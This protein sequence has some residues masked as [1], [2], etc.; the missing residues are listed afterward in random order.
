MR[1]SSCQQRMP[2]AA[3]VAACLCALLT[4][5][6]A[7]PAAR[8]NPPPHASASAAGGARTASPRQRVIRVFT[9][10]TAAMAGAF[11]SRN[12]R[13]VHE[14]LSRYLDPATIRN[15]IR[16]F[17]QAWSH[18]EISYGR[19]E[20]HII[21]VRIQG[22]TAWVHDCDNT[23]R[24][25]LGLRQV[26]PARAR[27]AG[28]PRPKSAD[29]AQPRPR[30]LDRRSADRRG[31]AVHRGLTAAGGGMGISPAG[32]TPPTRCDQDRRQTD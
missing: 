12:P 30:S 17:S 1:S 6:C 7:N 21:G 26:G 22:A 2:A 5:S 10:Y 13:R 25:G 32:G 9:G 29:Q 16:T 24:S 31:R 18:D 8:Q 27:V 14:L 4:M 23:S 28:N 19:P 20:D 11:S 3:Q 15:V